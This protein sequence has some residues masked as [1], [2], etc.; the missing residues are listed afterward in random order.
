M[1]EKFNV[2]PDVLIPRDETEILVRKAVEIINQNDFKEVLDMCSGSGCISCMVAK[3][4]NAHVIGADISLDT[5][6]V[7]FSNMEK[8]ELFNHAT[9]RK[10]DLFSKIREEEKFDVIISNP[11]YVAPK[12][13]ENLQ[14]EVTF[15]P[16]L[17]LFTSDEKGLE[18]YDKITKDATKFLNKGGYLLF[19]LG[20]DQSKEVKTFMQNNGFSKIEIIKDLAQI[21]RVI[22]GRLE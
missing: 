7:A 1:G 4:T 10:S 3:L 8:M 21:D 6:H 12:F 13:K 14:K 18:F 20:I 17:A 9:F 2:T 11:P 19:E 15:E 22:I 16:E 5:L